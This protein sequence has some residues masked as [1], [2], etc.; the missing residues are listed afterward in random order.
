MLVLSWADHTGA[1]AS[2]DLYSAEEARP[3]TCDTGAEDGSSDSAR[4]T[5]PWAQAVREA[6]ASADP[7][8]KWGV[9]SAGLSIVAWMVIKFLLHMWRTWTHLSADNATHVAEDNFD[10]DL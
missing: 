3:V 2:G 1:V 8:L 7:S 5:H 10:D 4:S 9:N 6:Y